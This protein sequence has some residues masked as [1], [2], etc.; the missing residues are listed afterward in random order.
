MD[1]NGE[2]DKPA[3]DSTGTGDVESAVG[4]LGIAVP[5]AVADE[6]GRDA[7]DRPPLQRFVDVDALERLFVTE[8]SEVEV[9]FTYDGVHITVEDDGSITV[10]Q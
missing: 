10:D 2:A 5:R 7:L 4:R 3:D 1:R 9:S 6:T 8:Q